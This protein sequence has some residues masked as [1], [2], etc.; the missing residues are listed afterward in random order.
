MK[1]SKF[2]V[3][4]IPL[5]VIICVGI[6]C[7][8]VKTTL[9]NTNNSNNIVKDAKEI[10]E[11]Y[12]KNNND[13]YLVNLSE[14]NVYKYIS[15]DN[16]KELLNNKEGLIFVG[17]PN[18]NIARKNI[19]VL[20]DVVSSTSVPQVYYIDAI[21]EYKNIII[22]KDDSVS[23]EPGTLIAVEGGKI[24]N[25]Y[26]PNYVSDDKELKDAERETLFNTYK[27]IVNKFIEECDE[28]C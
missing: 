16:L 4:F 12:A 23:L 9:K 13:Y 27:E 17:D 24:L 1:D 7:M 21:N 10:K 28:N 14:N 26:Y 22:E 15:K 25:D 6:Y 3:W 8:L 2:W 18:N 5:F 11:L 20:N 19:V